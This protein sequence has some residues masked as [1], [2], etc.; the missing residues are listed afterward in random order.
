MADTMTE[1]IRLRRTLKR[2]ADCPSTA[3]GYSADA[4]MRAGIAL[5]EWETCGDWDSVPAQVVWRISESKP[6]G[7]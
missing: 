1:A 7:A 3:P 5:V 2:A 6:S 4:S